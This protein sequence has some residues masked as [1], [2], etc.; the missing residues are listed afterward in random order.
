MAPPMATM[1]HTLSWSRWA[2]MVVQGGAQE[3]QQQAQQPVL[4]QPPLLVGA[5]GEPG[6]HHLA[7]INS[8][9]LQP[10]LA[11]GSGNQNHL[12]F[13]KKCFSSIPLF[14]TYNDATFWQ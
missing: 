6:V 9:K 8:R 7:R 13:E 10:D 14:T 3:H 2:G 4:R 1:L 12:S 11:A 5:G